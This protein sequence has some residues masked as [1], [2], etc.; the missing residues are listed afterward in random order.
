MAEIDKSGELKRK[1]LIK[2]IAEKVEVSQKVV[3][4]VINETFNLIGETLIDDNKVVVNN[5][6][7]FKPT[8]RAARRGRNPQTGQ[9]LQIPESRSIK[10]TISSKFKEKLRK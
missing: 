8:I 9:P 6:G 2:L 4:D 5:F 7:S 1:D 10:F 3:G